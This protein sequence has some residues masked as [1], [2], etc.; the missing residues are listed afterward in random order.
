VSLKR[1]QA[2][3]TLVEIMIA[4]GIAG[5][6]TLVSMTV[7]KNFQQSRQLLDDQVELEDFKLIV[8]TNLRCKET[9]A[10]IGPT[11]SANK[12]VPIMGP[13]TA[14]AKLKTLIPAAGRKIQDYQVVARCVGAS[15]KE[16]RITYVNTKTPGAAPKPLFVPPLGCP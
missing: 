14:P 3:L 7:F 6:V 1:G 15:P 10:A 13:A 5:V 9:L 4:L 16:W 11:C 8:R 12:A 2:G